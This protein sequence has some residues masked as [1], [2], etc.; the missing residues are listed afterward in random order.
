ME[1]DTSAVPPDYKEALF[2]QAV[3]LLNSTSALNIAITLIFYD[4]LIISLSISFQCVEKRTIHSILRQER[5]RVLKGNVVEVS[6]IYPH[7]NFI[8]HV[9]KSFTGKLIKVAF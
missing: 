4:S 5:H 8:M 7:S 1:S 6:Y 3:R 2:P 9:Y